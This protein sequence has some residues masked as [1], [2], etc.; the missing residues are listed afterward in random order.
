MSLNQNR[1]INIT[2]V[3]DIID[4]GQTPGTRYLRKR[5]FRRQRNVNR[6]N[7]QLNASINSE[8]LNRITNLPRQITNDSILNQFFN[9]YP[10]I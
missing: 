8:T 2:P 5:R 9:G 6:R 7:I 3:I 4:N 1:L 10:L